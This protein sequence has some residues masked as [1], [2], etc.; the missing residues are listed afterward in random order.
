MGREDGPHWRKRSA[1]ESLEELVRSN[2]AS[3]CWTR[4]E[5]TSGG[6]D[7]RLNFKRFEYFVAVRVD[8]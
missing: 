6:W 7:E 1:S 2:I 4:R 5:S 8:C 3:R